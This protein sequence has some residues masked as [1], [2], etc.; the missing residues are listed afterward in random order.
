M[1]ILL[2]AIGTRGDVQPFVVL[3]KGLAQRGHDV[4]IA[5]AKGFSRM[6]SKAGLC[7]HPLPV[8]MQELMQEPQIAAAMSSLSGK[9]KAY[10]WA[11]EIMNAQL[12]VIWKIG[13][14]VSPDL[15][16]HHFKGALGPYLARKLGAISAPIM[17]QPGFMAT[18]E[19]PQFLI[20]S[21]SLGRVGNMASHRLINAVMQFGTSMMIKRWQ[22]IAQPDLGPP[23]D[24]MQS[25]SPKG[26]APRI[27]AYSKAIVPRPASWPKTEVQ[28]GYLFAEPQDF[29]PP[30]ALRAF[31]DAGP[32]PVYFGFGSMPGVDRE[33]IVDAVTGAVRNLK[34]RAIFAT[35]WSGI[36]QIKSMADIHVLDAVPH[37]WLFPQVSA[38]VHH[39]G[40][41]TT[42]EGLRW[43]CPSVICPLFAD[44]P[45]F[46]QRVADL[47][48]GPPPIAQKRLT[49]QKLTAAL[50]IA[51]SSSVQER[52]AAIGKKLYAE[53]G[54]ASV[55][56]LVDRGF[57]S[58]E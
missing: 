47:G 44:Q 54:V 20:A 55:C 43:G 6:I 26:K 49:A 12:D 23:M 16:L 10:R 46:G 34:L 42:H 38:V 28:S 40:S 15:I 33:R 35:G 17:L 18:G 45:F 21:R 39:G 4:S 9:L 56:D 8:D 29:T 58:P 2:I 11:S 5:A 50:E 22:K 7:H 1:K 25:Y 37:T 19:Y 30:E 13:L 24:L 52:A 14:N 32:S 57:T 53:D 3:G 31:L 51:L 48:A 41:G 36:T 27:H